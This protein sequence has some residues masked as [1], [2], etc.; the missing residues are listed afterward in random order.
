M[1][2]IKIWM[3]TL[4]LRSWGQ[5]EDFIGKGEIAMISMLIHIL[6]EKYPKVLKTKII[7]VMVFME[8]I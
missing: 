3:V 8:K 2:L 6:V 5:Q 1:S 7:I 4:I